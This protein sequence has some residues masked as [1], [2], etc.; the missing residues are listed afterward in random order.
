MSEMAPPKIREFLTGLRE[1]GF[2][3]VKEGFVDTG[4]PQPPVKTSAA[5]KP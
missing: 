3:D 1:D 5:V 4:A 2:V